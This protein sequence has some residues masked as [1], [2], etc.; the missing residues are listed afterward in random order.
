MGERIVRLREEKGWDRGELARRLG[1]TRARLKNWERG[2]NMPPVETLVDL[3]G[4]LDVSLDE[5]VTGE[6]AGRLLTPEECQRLG[7]HLAMELSKMRR[8]APADLDGAGSPGGT[9]P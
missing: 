5:L 1:V 4:A 8:K 2:T 3:G 9:E 6:V 7:E